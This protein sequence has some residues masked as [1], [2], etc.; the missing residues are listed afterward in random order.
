MGP[1]YVLKISFLHVQLIFSLSSLSHAFRAKV[2]RYDSNETG[3]LERS[4]RT[5]H[6]LLLMCVSYDTITQGSKGM[7]F[8][9]KAGI[10]RPALTTH[11][12]A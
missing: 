6:L 12:L 8:K 2:F 3:S 1:D 5:E 10:I 7:V 4:N 9:D 11:L